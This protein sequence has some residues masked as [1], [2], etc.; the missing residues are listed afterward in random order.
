LLLLYVLPD[1]HVLVP[2]KVRLG[3][4]PQTWQ[5]AT[6]V[7]NM[8]TGLIAAVLCGNIGIKV[9]YI[10]SSRDSFTSKAGKM[11]W[12]GLVPLYWVIAWVV[13]AAIPQFSTI[14]SLDGDLCILQ[15]THTSPEIIALNSRS[16]KLP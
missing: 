2:G 13:C 7:M 10:K 14:S 12:A 3:L 16:R 5:T 1:I 4:L 6:N 15:F 9:C 11:L 8:V